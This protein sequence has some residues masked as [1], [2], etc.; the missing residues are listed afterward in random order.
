MQAPCIAVLLENLAAKADFQRVVAAANVC[1]CEL[2]AQV[3]VALIDLQAAR[4]D[5]ASGW[6]IVLFAPKLHHALLSAADD[7]GWT[8]PPG[9]Y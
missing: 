8:T 9:R 6:T 1:R 3:S 2:K 5:I 4:T 7:R